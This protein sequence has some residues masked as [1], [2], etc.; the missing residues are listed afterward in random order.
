[1]PRLALIV[2][3][4]ICVLGV[5]STRAAPALADYGKLP[6]VEDMRLSPSGDTLA[7]VALDGEARKVVVRALTG[8]PTPGTGPSPLTASTE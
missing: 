1:M 5:H 6:A 2:A 4:A 3:L 8:D 7:Y